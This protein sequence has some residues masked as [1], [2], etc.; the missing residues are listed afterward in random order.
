[1]IQA[2]QRVFARGGGEVEIRGDNRFVFVVGEFQ[3][4][5]I[6][7]HDLGISR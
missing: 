7:R 6:G 4:S 3:D 1:M 5:H 2:L